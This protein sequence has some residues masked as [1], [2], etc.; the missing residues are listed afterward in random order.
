MRLHSAG[1]A[2]RSVEPGLERRCL[3]NNDLVCSNED[4]TAGPVGGRPVGGVAQRVTGAEILPSGERV[5][6]SG[7]PRV[8]QTGNHHQQPQDLR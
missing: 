3:G 1:N 2:S 8:D 4:E 7:D 5:F 6:P